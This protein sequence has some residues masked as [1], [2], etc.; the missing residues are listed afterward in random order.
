MAEIYEDCTHVS[1]MGSLG[2]ETGVKCV[3]ILELTTCY[4]TGCNRVLLHLAA[5]SMTLLASWLTSVVAICL[6]AA[7]ST[8]SMHPDPCCCLHRCSRCLI[9]SNP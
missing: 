9:R 7:L 4:M 6:I 2:R 1:C 5:P 3:L 8:T